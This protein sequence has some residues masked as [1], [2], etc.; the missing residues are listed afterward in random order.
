MV[1]DYNFS[2]N[3][4]PSTTTTEQNLQNS[5]AFWLDDLVQINF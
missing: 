5:L 2:D 3:L 1:L 4:I